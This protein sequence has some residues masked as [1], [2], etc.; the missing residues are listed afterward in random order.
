MKFLRLLLLT[1]KIKIVKYSRNTLN[2]ETAKIF[3]C[4]NFPSYGM[5]FAVEIPGGSGPGTIYD[6][7]LFC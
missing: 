1:A 5:S 3:N 4:E 2:H 7:K 6:G